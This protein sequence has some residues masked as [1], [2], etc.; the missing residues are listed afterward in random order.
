MNSTIQ[1]DTSIY[2]RGFLGLVGGTAAAAT[3]TAFGGAPITAWVFTKC[4]LQ[5]SQLEEQL[6]SWD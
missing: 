1:T 2:K 6:A 5:A 4:P 3:A